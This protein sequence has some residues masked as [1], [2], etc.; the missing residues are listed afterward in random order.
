VRFVRLTAMP[1]SCRAAYSCMRLSGTTGATCAAQ[2][3]VRYAAGVTPATNAV[4]EGLQPRARDSAARQLQRLVRRRAMTLAAV[5]TPSRLTR[6]RDNRGDEAHTRCSR[7]LNRVETQR[8]TRASRN[9]SGAALCAVA[10]TPVHLA[11]TELR[12][13]SSVSRKLKR[14][15]SL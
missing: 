14:S 3:R 6:W 12:P 7:R 4:N 1:L 11:K 9:A 8:A 15:I 2:R 10:A 13:T 5:S